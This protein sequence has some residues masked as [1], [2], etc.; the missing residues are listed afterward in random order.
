[1][2]YDPAS[3]NEL[4]T[5]PESLRL[6]PMVE[7]NSFPRLVSSIGIEEARTIAYLNEEKNDQVL[8]LFAIKNFKLDPFNMTK[9]DFHPVG[10]AAKILALEEPDTEGDP[11]KVTI[12]GLKRI[13]IKEIDS[14][15]PTVKVSPVE[16]SNELDDSLRP[17]ILEA[18]RLF[19]EAIMLIP[20]QPLN[21]FKINRT[22]ENQPSVLADL[23]M[24]SL[25]LKP[26]VKAEFLKIENLKARYHRLLEYLTIEVANRKA[27]RAIS[28]RMEL[29][30]ASRQKEMHLRE[31]LKA[32]REELGENDETNGIAEIVRRLDEAGLPESAR[33]SANRDIQRLKQTP[34]HS[35]EYSQIRNYMDWL[36]E[37]PWAKKSEGETDLAKARKILDRDHH[38]L[39]K[40]KKRIL[41]FLAVHKLTDNLKAPILC[42]TGP[43]GVGKT[44]LGRSIA[45]ATGRK[46]H[47][48]SLGG[49][50]DEAEIR[51]HRR[52]YVGANPGRIVS[53]LRKIGVNNP[54]FLL[55][56]VDKMGQSHAGDPAAALLEVL[57]P[58]Q[59]DTFTDNYLE[60]PFD[61]SNVMF[62]LTANVAENIPAAL[63]DRLEIIE[64]TGYAVEE[65]IDIAQ[66]HLWSKEL[67]RNGLSADEA[68]IGPEEIQRLITGYTWEAGCRDLS[69]KLGAL[70]RGRAMAK[71]EGL[72]K[73]LDV[74]QDEIKTVL[75]PPTRR[76]E[77]K[78]EK[79][80]Q[81][82][83]VTG[84]AWTAAGGDIMFVEAVAMPGK[85]NLSLTG[86]LG[87]VMK[88][89]AQA[90]LCLVRSRARD[91]FL[92]ESWFKENDVH[93]HLPH[94]A[95]PKD[96][97]SAGVSLTTAIVSLISG[98]KVRPDV[99]MT[100]EITLRGLVLPIGGVKEK[101]LAAKRAGITTVLIPEANLAE[102]QQLSPSVTQGLRIQ[103][104]A[105]MDDVLERALTAPDGLFVP[106]A[107]E[108]PSL[109]GDTI[110]AWTA[111]LKHREATL[112][113]KILPRD[114]ARPEPSKLNV[115]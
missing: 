54:V 64:V 37:L 40:V 36:I 81:I 43:P 4:F 85:G 59:N 87:D 91:W 102:V 55:D 69:R 78:R 100:G 60:M 46:F 28:A 11:I 49:I 10:V 68:R 76:P 99:A 107:Y 105:N 20:G 93:I 108:P 112:K 22:L 35:A 6:L 109:N 63:R 115:A 96:G 2:E 8:A 70:A 82:G 84:L 95:I 58:E 51:G 88:E 42:L 50:R 1:M 12:L 39:E 33:A 3:E 66:R 13:T 71:A 57:D 94:G 32:I 47:R 52:T 113:T 61:L 90:A 72:E 19:A 15:G 106:G 38:G 14:Q 27:G 104:V 101:L 65:K 73:P 16:D 23:I 29:S 41:E 74:N 34:P 92:R 45:E 83:V 17:L 21:L 98:Q 53:G 62:V 75:G 24:S 7:L 30:L 103:T 18:K 89:S 79:D 48:L 31:Q 77:D 9:E 86:Q 5:V 25:P 44:S 80:P 110:D 67:E 56:E 26:D 97:P 111:A 114:E